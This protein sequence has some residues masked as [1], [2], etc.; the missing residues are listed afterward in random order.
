LDRNFFKTSFKLL[1][2]KFES[3][4]WIYKDGL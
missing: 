4:F 1:V 3:G 2:G